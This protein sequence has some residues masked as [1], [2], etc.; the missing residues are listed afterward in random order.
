MG[1]FVWAQKQANY[2]YFGNGRKLDFSSG[3]PVSSTGP[4][5]AY[6]GTCSVSDEKGNL[7]FYTD[8]TD[9]IWNAA[10]QVMYTMQGTG[11]GFSS[12]QTSVAFEAPG[13][14]CVYYLFTMEQV[15]E[16][17]AGRGL[18]YFKIDMTQNNG[19]GAVTQS[20]TP[21]QTPSFEG[22]CAIRHSNKRD[23]WVVI[24]QGYSGLGVYKVTASGVSLHNVFSVSSMGTKGMIKASP[25]GFHVI[26]KPTEGDPLLPYTPK[27][28][29]FSFDP[30]TGV[31]S[32]PETL[33]LPA[34]NAR[35]EF[36]PNSRW[37]FL[38][39]SDE[40][41][42]YD[43]LSS[44]VGLSGMSVFGNLNFGGGASDTQLG[45]DG[46]I[47][48]VYADYILATGFTNTNL[49]RILCPNNTNPVFEPNVIVY[50]G[51]ST[52][53][54]E[55]IG[56]PNFPAYV[57]RNTQDAFVS[58]GPDTLFLTD[59]AGPITLNALN[60]G[61]S[62]LW[63]NGATTQTI[64]V[65][66]AGTYSVTVTGSCGTG[67]D[68]I[69]VANAATTISATGDT[70]G[71]T[72]Y[73]FSVVS[74]RPTALVEWNFGDNS[75]STN[76]SNQPAATHTFSGPGTY[77]V[78]AVIN[79]NC[80]L[81][82]I[83][84]I[85][86]IS[87]CVD[88]GF[89]EIKIQGDSCVQTSKTFSLNTNLNIQQVFEWNFGD[90]LSGSSNVGSGLTA[91]HTFS[92]AGTYTVRCIAEINCSPPVSITNPITFPCF[93]VDTAYLEITIVPCEVPEPECFIYFSNSFTPN[94]DAQNN[95]FGPVTECNF[96]V[97]EFTIFNRW[98]EAIYTTTDSSSPWSGM[99]GNA[100]AP[101][102][103]YAYTCNYKLP[104]KSFQFTHG[105]VNLMR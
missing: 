29:L 87:T 98:G 21:V 67:T 81:D 53:Y 72:P 48:M 17:P 65:N 18:R 91:N 55:F 58:L 60:P 88:T 16:Y 28:L 49:H 34:A 64:T 75:S 89:V 68:Q 11:G 26:T 78:K 80:K 93:Y 50:P 2:W 95:V 19:L 70:C 74:N 51:P 79:Q 90:A 41:I 77:T 38:P 92:S 7:L 105:F 54:V 100:A 73:T 14:P 43:L 9:K 6:E 56:L 25:D 66:S 32:N 4:V 85:V 20:Y 62:Y 23:F 27:V 30:S 47:Y 15:E 84:T 39:T 63:S 12:M 1:S 101:S 86:T 40:I 31:L 45:P 104:K 10:N 69:V 57:F 94:D 82:T 37:L 96:E 99:E 52:N 59:Y 97:F 36:S 71:T 24:H 61:A 13:E 3:L 35:Y 33:T 83:Q 44:P 103:I 46:N 8:G 22:L 5:V 102:G 76:T 42:R